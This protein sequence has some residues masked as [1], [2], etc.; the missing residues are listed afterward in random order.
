MSGVT[1]SR[2]TVSV[3][4]LEGAGPRSAHSPVQVARQPPAAPRALPELPFSVCCLAGAVRESTCSP[5]QVAR[6]PPRA[7]SRSSRSQSWIQ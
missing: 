5:V 4:C 2:L 3:C 1:R 7:R 6:Q